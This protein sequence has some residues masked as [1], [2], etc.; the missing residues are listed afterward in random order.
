VLLSH[1]IDLINVALTE[2]EVIRGMKLGYIHIL[3]YNFRFERKNFQIRTL[4]TYG[5]DA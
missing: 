4:V 2:S 5:R 3:I 1:L